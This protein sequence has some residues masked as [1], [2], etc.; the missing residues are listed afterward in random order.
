MSLSS[1]AS[2]IVT[3]K[4]GYKNNSSSIAEIEVK[5]KHFLILLQ[6]SFVNYGRSIIKAIRRKS[7]SKR[8]YGIS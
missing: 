6:M 2:A 5:K 4:K 7:D 3:Q 8:R 1:E